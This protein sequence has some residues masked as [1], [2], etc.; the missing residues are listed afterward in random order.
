MERWRLCREGVEGKRAEK[1]H[2]ALGLEGL[3][4]LEGADGGLRA[5]ADFDQVEG[6]FRF[7]GDARLNQQG[8]N[9]AGVDQPREQAVGAGK[10]GSHDPLVEEG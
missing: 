10:R 2:D 7:G 3:E 8:M 6:V 4:Q 5:G 9:Q 1:A